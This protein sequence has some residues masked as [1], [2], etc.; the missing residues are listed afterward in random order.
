MKLTLESV[1]EESG[2]LTYH[3]SDKEIHESDLLD[4]LSF[5]RPD[6][7]LLA[8]LTDKSRDFDQR[9]EALRWNAL[10]RRSPAR[11]FTGARIDLIPHQLAIVAEVSGRLYP[12]VLLADEVGL[13]KNHRSLPHTPS[14]APHRSRR[15]HTDSRAGAVGAP[16]VRRIAEKI[17]YA[18]CNLR[19][20]T[21][22]IRES[23]E[24]GMVSPAEESNP[25]SE[26]QLILCA[27]DF[28]SEN[29]TRAKQA[30]E[31]GFDLLIVDE[32]H[33]LEWSEEDASPAYLPSSPSRR[34]YHLSFF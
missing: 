11:G 21:L 25:F 26:S 31:A 30:R 23:D 18:L 4:S 2:L 9:L 3:G 5:I 17:Q 29:E 8:G 6:K 34:P 22:P 33:H 1:S 13:G 10:I 12:R 20:R 7:R 28:L 15:P 14:S 24:E 19:R 32:A 16:M 27:T